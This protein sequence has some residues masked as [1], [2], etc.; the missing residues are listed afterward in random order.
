MFLGLM[1]PAIAVQSKPPAQQSQPELS[2]ADALSQQGIQQYR[3]NQFDA[4]IASWQQALTLYRQQQNHKGEVLCLGRLG[5]AYYAVGNYRKAIEYYRQQLT[6]AR[7]VGDRPSEANA[8]ADLGSSYRTLGNYTQAEEYTQKSLDLRRH[9][10]DRIGEGRVLA[11]LGNIQVDLGKYESAIALYQQSLDIA[12]RVNDQRGMVIVSNSLGALYAAQGDDDRARQFYEQSLQGARKLGFRTMEANAL[13]NLGSIDQVQGNFQQAIAHYQ[14]SLT[15]AKDLKDLH[16]EGG[17]LAGL[18]LGYASLK[19]FAAALRYQEQSWQIARQLGNRKLEGLALGN[20]GDTLWQSGKLKEAEE[21]IRMALEIL[22]SLRTDLSD[23]DKISIFDT[24]LLSYNILQQILIA[25]NR[26][27]SALEIAERGR[28]R[29][30]VELL[31][32]RLA[33]QR[34][35]AEDRR[36]KIEENKEPSTPNPELR[37]PTSNPLSPTISQIQQI[38]R[39]QQATLVEYS[40][41]PDDRFIAQGKLKGPEIELF[42]WV[43]QPTGKVDFRRVD[44]RPL[45]QENLSLS[46]IV[47]ASRCLTP[48]RACRSL[49]RS[50]SRGIGVVSADE[51]SEVQPNA[52]PEDTPLNPAL[53][54]LHQLLIQPI[55][56]LL[57]TDPNARIVFIPQESLFLVPFSALQDADGKFLISQHTILTAP[58]IQVLDLTNQQRQRIQ[59]LHPTS[60]PAPR[61]PD[62]APL[63]LVVGNPTMPLVSPEPG[64]PPQQLPA[65]PAAEQEAKR[66]A[67]LLKTQAIIGAQATKVSIEQKLPQARFIHLAT[68]GLL[69]YGT[70]QKHISLQGVGVP[71]AIAL[72]PSQGSDGLLTASNI[73]DLRLNAELVVLSACDTGRGRIT[74]DGVVG[75]SR[76]FISAGVPSV[77]VSLW[78]VPDAPTAQL[79]VEFYQNLQR[80]PDKAQAL[81]QAMLT[82]MQQYPNPLNWS[83]F[84]LI[85]E[86]N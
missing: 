52:R 34:Q 83:A 41:I 19:D 85:G 2:P 14:Q 47:T 66:I 8:L 73:L 65:L 30:F 80:N 70:Q 81:R 24:Q 31:S 50:L 53:Q 42:I 75:L 15:V 68:H 28:A 43:V 6:L 10:N 55:A 62:F 45:H 1:A 3:S 32:R 79:M 74:G 4:A 86:A 71:G 78:S 18:G 36:Q 16:I 59:A 48:T 26:P 58:A 21:K 60:P 12:L 72:A 5:L 77:L 37:T 76:A 13:N 44:L 40:I 46:K 35:K 7:Q 64:Q 82:T 20:L 69:E 63:A 22:E 25:Q 17:A 27:E 33:G 61:P 84:T 54:R 11:N 56:D 39:Q 9:L 49:V 23:A 29:A 51:Q 57:P 67:N 38:A